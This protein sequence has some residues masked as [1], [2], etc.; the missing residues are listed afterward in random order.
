MIYFI[1]LLYFREKELALIKVNENDINILM[2]EF[3]ITYKEADHYLRLNNGELVK[4]IN[5]CLN[6]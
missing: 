1:I 4:T 3:E 5:Y 6:K 2:S